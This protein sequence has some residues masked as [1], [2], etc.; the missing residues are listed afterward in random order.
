[1]HIVESS[2]AKLDKASE[3]L[4]LRNRDDH[5]SGL[6]SCHSQVLEWPVAEP[7]RKLVAVEII[8]VII[9]GEMHASVGSC[10]GFSTA[11]GGL[12]QTG[13]RRAEQGFLSL[14]FVKTKRWV[15]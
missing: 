13:K 7:Q 4:L 8:S 11:L 1:M 6:P 9:S 12:C 3:M 14:E 15:V 10:L 2:Q 5:Y